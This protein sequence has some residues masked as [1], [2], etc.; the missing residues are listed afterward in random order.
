MEQAVEAVEENFVVGL[1]FEFLGAVVGDGGADED[2]AVGK[3]DDVGLGGVVHELAVDA[4][5]G[6][7][8][9]QDDVDFRELRRQR[10]RQERDRRLKPRQ[11]RTDLDRR[12]ALLV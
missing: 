10:A 1:E 4:R 2:F 8:V 11:K 5:D 12:L 7:A 6:G 9:D 3:G